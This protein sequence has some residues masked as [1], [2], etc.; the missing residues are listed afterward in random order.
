MAF[1]YTR[2][3]LKTIAH[4]LQFAYNIVWKQIF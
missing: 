4:F 3:E 2:V 1:I